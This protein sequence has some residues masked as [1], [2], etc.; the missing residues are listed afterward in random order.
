MVLLFWKIGN[1]MFLQFLR[2]LVNFTEF[3]QN[4]PKLN[5]WNAMKDQVSQFL[6][7]PL[8]LEP[9]HTSMTP[10][11]FKFWYDHGIFFTSINDVY[12]FHN[13]N[14]SHSPLFG[15]LS[16]GWHSV[17]TVFFW[18]KTIFKVMEQGSL[19]SS[20]NCP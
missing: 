12:N 8:S 4:I 17:K 6:Q 16:K 2:N 15:R 10:I 1:N 3:E 14:Y 11:N 13:K 5:F 7:K 19:E 18:R 9:I 20:C